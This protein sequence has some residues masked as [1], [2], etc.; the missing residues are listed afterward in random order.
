[1]SVANRISFVSRVPCHCKDGCGVGGPPPY[2]LLPLG[3]NVGARSPRCN[4]H[5]AYTHYH[6]IP[7]ISTTLSVFGLPRFCPWHATVEVAHIKLCAFFIDCSPLSLFTE[8]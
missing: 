3:R 2:R 4:T 1:M 6:T 5:G 7:S 8:K